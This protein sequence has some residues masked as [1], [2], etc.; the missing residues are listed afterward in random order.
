MSSQANLLARRAAVVADGLPRVTDVVV[1][2]GNGAHLETPDG[3]PIID[4][5]GGIGV[6]NV[7]HCHPRV[8]R[9]IQEQASTLLHTCIHVATYEPY[10]A[11]CEKLVTLLPHGTSTKALLVNS[12]AEAVENAVKIARQA[13]GRQGI[14]CFTEG[15]HGRTLLGM[16]LTSKVGYKA[17]CGPFAPEVYRIPFPN[18]YR[19]GDGLSEEAFVEREVRRLRDTFV[20][21]AAPDQLAAV[22]IEPIQGEGGFVPAPALY[23]Q[24]LR[25]ICDDHGILLICDEV[26]SGFCRTGRWASYEHYGIVPDLSTWAKSLGGGMPIGAVLGRADVM[27]AA[28]PGTIGGTYGGNPVACAAALASIDVMSE[29]DLGTR[30]VAIGNTIR[31]RLTALARRCPAIGD[32]RGLGAMIGMELV[33]DRVTKEPAGKLAAMVV[34]RAAERGVLVIPAGSHGNVLRI[35]CPL[36]IA[37]AYLEQGLSII[38]EELERAFA[39]K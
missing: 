11:L 7:G 36:V 32:V 6:M 30:A 20:N 37:D 39:S 5:A 34:A 2:S 25:E 28:R 38:E 33:V 4:F 23:L 13:T 21:T 17:G 9:A 14:L 26:Q 27:D 16:T 29:E 35:L 18:Y 1:H 15:F 19:Y 8:V 24:K 10:V 3:R 22:L 31:S 12:G